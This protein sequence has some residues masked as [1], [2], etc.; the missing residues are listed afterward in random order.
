MHLELS[1]LILDV[2]I[3]LINHAA[4]SDYKKIDVINFQANGRSIITRS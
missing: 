1:C 2:H 4:E 3:S